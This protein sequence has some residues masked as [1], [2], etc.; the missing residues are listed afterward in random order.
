M[1]SEVK[2]SIEVEWSEVKRIVEV[3]WSEVKRSVEVRWSEVKIF[4]ELLI[5]SWTYIYVDCMRVTV[6][7]ALLSR[8]LIAILFMFFHCYVLINYVFKFILF[9]FFFLALYVFLNIL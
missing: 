9:I 3:E 8:Y 1:G 7:Y 6:E 2:W 4:G 5:L